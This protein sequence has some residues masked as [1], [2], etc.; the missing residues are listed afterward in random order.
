MNELLLLLS[1]AAM[2]GAAIY[3][4]HQGLVLRKINKRLAGVVAELEAHPIHLTVV[5]STSAKRDNA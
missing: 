4:G 5:D 2:I 3:M 1:A